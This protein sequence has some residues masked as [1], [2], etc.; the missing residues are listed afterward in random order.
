[1]RGV[2]YSG[3]ALW[4]VHVLM[5]RWLC[6][7]F[8]LNSRV[9]DMYFA[10]SPS[11]CLHIPLKWLVHDLVLHWLWCLFALI[12]R[13]SDIYSAY[14]PHDILIFQFLW[15]VIYTTAVQSRAQY[16]SQLKAVGR[17]ETFESWPSEKGVNSKWKTKKKTCS[18]LIGSR[19]SQKYIARF[20]SCS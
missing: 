10:Q 18:W 5:L 19:L 17:A 7:W 4:L 8:A 1:M 13:L 11:W 3:G 2:R 14:V 16:I 6:S 12:S 15:C 9:S 20:A